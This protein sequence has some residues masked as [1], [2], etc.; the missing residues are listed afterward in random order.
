MEKHSMLREVSGRVP[1]GMSCQAREAFG[2]PCST[3]RKKLTVGEL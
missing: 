3:V 2:S 1:F